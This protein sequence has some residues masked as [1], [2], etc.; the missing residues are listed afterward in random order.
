MG[1][2]NCHG[3]LLPHNVFTGEFSIS[4]LGFLVFF[5]TPNSPSWTSLFL[6]HS[7]PKIHTH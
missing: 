5:W 3:V 2:R 4:F 6:P 1:S 7:T